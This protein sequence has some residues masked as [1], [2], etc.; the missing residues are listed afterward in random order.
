MVQFQAGYFL[1]SIKELFKN[2]ELEN[3]VNGLLRSLSYFDVQFDTELKP[4]E[5]DAAALAV[6][7]G[8]IVSRGLPT[9]SSEFV[10]EVIAEAFRET[11]NKM[12][13]YIQN[14]SDKDA[15]RKIIF[16]ALH[17][18]EP[19]IKKEEITENFYK[20]WNQTANEFEESFYYAYSPQYL[21]EIFLQLFERKRPLI[22]LIEF[23]DP[24]KELFLQIRNSDEN[25]IMNY[26]FDLSIEFPYFIQDKKGIVVEIEDASNDKT[27]RLLVAQKHDEILEKS[28]WNRAFRYES[29]DFTNLN[30]KIKPLLKFL[31]NDFTDIVK[32]NF[33]TPLFS[34]EPGLD[35]LQLAL[36]PISIARIQKIII[37]FIVAGKLKFTDKEWKI[38]IIERDIPCGALA[39][40]DLKQLLTNLCKLKYDDF[41]FPDIIL[42]VF[43]T[44][45][46]QKTRLD[47]ID[48]SR[49]TIQYRNLGLDKF[50]EFTKYNVLI[51]HSI[52]Q[53]SN[54]DISELKHSADNN[55]IIRSAMSINSMYQ[56][57]CYKPILYPSFLKNNS[58]R[59]RVISLERVKSLKYFL[60]MIFNK[61]TFLSGQ[62]EI[63]NEALQ[64]NNVLGIIPP[65]GGKT[66]CFQLAAMLQPLP[67]LV[68]IPNSVMAVDQMMTL[69]SGS[70]DMAG[71]I[72]FL[73]TKAIEKEY[74]LYEMTESHYQIYYVNPSLMLSNE[75]KVSVQ[76]HTENKFPFCYVIIDE[77]QSQSEWNPE[78]RIEYS[79]LKNNL[80]QYF[81]KEKISPVYLAMTS[82][83]S[84]DVQTQIKS[85][86]KIQRIIEVEQSIPEISYQVLEVTS[87]NLFSNSDL[88]NAK[89][90][91]A[92]RKQVQISYLINDKY[93]KVQNRNKTLIFCPHKKGSYGITDQ[94]NEG[95][96]DKLKN[97]FPDLTIA[98]FLG[99]ADDKDDYTDNQNSEK[100]VRNFIDFRD[101]K[102]D[103]MVTSRSLSNG[104]ALE[105]VGSVIFINFPD[106]IEYFYK[107][108]GRLGKAIEHKEVI[109]LFNTQPIQF[110][111]YEIINEAGIEKKVQ[112]EINSSIDKYFAKDKIRQ[113]YKGYKKEISIL[114]ELLNQ[115]TYPVEKPADTILDAIEE[116]FGIHVFFAFL[117][118][119]NPFQLFINKGDKT[120]GYIDF[121]DHTI[122]TNVATLD[123]TE[124]EQIL[125]FA[126]NLMD[127]KCPRS[128]NIFRWLTNVIENPVLE[129]INALFT[130]LQVGESKEINIHFRNNMVSQI[131]DMLNTNISDSFSEKIIYNICRNT[132]SLSAFL[133]KLN[134]IANINL[135]NV[136]INV[137]EEISKLYYKIR[138]E[139]DT[140][141]ALYRLSLLGVVEY[142]TVDFESKMIT[143]L[144]KKRV[145]EEYIKAV[146][147][148][149]NQFISQEHAAKYCLQMERIKGD[150]VLEK[151][152]LLLVYFVYKEIVPKKIASINRMEGLCKYA[153][154][155]N[156]YAGSISHDFNDYLSKHFKNQYASTL[157][158]PN[159]ET[160][161]Q[162]FLA[163]NF[164]TIIKF[165]QEIRELKENWFHL[166]NSTQFFLNKFPDKY[167]LMLLNA[168]CS[169]LLYADNPKMFNSSFDNLAKGVVIMAKEEKLRHLDYMDK[170]RIFLNFIYEHNRELKSVIEPLFY[171]KTH[172]TWLQEFNKKFC[173]ALSKNP[174][175]NTVIN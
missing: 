118:D 123:K 133:E 120:F 42:N 16:D 105:N 10:E 71:Y 107:A 74:R 54:L 83:A 26:S 115:V 112:R 60:K 79:L 1:E 88:P 24:N 131:C 52:L 173:S 137:P 97:G 63:M 128:R 174:L 151:C 12:A 57:R 66:I 98:P 13:N 44:P 140:F 166:F 147:I 41:K 167:G 25:I 69:H 153:L 72:P 121:R 113:V 82:I 95:L 53:R 87:K 157:V 7:A 155:K 70:I 119:K 154:A 106:S 172:T 108:I 109:I 76:K 32:N 2:H 47:K 40:E 126:K 30:T 49:I 159:L 43:S 161:S 175:Q 38:G 21:G 104:I 58:I 8:N 146:F 50:S 6:V 142:L 168:Y 90:S 17:I 85:D 163:F 93:V 101:N 91:I 59:E 62:I 124:S 64:L 143:V 170:I 127:K 125:E 56:Y 61:T 129:G 162:D 100:S 89:S 18:I 164:T 135:I 33:I 136:N 149:L 150:T 46:F 75:F 27:N 34:S 169:F 145:D 4:V 94:N 36:T 102:L 31:N 156:K 29:I 68:I 81:T 141:T 117:P 138:T 20:Y 165:I 171:L 80:N 139:D 51:D 73:P 22:N 160:E 55:V 37:E 122:N 99:T 78:F 35:A 5:S 152:L 14:H 134:E 3:K 114:K 9:R 84:F 39:I 116:Q 67:S 11:S 96:Y 148:H 45:E 86:W 19:R 48:L 77:A 111:E 103:I 130:S 110:I 144:I 28:L 65:L 23:H 132:G 15:L 158:T 92:S